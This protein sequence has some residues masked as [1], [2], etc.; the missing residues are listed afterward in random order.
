MSAFWFPVHSIL[1]DRGRLAAIHATRLVDQ[2]SSEA[3]DSLTR[4]ACR[5][6][7][8]PIALVTMVEVERQFFA[9]A[10]GLQEPEATRREIPISHS[11]CQQVVTSGEQLVVGDAC[12]DRR[13]CDNPAVVDFNIGAYLGVPLRTPDGFVLGSFCVLDT[14]EREWTADDIA[15]VEDL[16][17]AAMA[18]LQGRTVAGDL[19]KATLEYAALLD[20]TTELVCASDAVGA[21]T[22]VNKAWCRAFG[23]RDADVIG[24]R[25]VD[26]VV[27]EHRAR[28][29]EVARRVHEGECSEDFEVMAMGNVGRRVVCRGTARATMTAQEDGTLRCTGTIGVYRDVTH[30]RQQEAA[31]ARLVATLEATSDLVYIAAASGEIDYLNRGG[32][33]LLGMREDQDLSALRSTAFHPADTQRLLETVGMPTARERGEWQGDG[34]VR[35]LDGQCIPVSI[36][37]TAHPGITPRDSFYFSAIMWDRRKQVAAD[38]AIRASEARLRAVIDNAAV[39][40]SIVNE[41]GMV[42]Q[43]NRAFETFLGY[44]PGELEGR[45]APDLSPASDA[46]ITR[47]PVES[48]RSGALLS[49]SVEKRFTRTDGTERWAALTLSRIPL[50]EHEYGILGLTT[51]ITRRREAEAA[52]R[53]SQERYRRLVDL[54]PDG[55]VMYSGG[56][57]RFANAAMARLVGLESA[58]MVVG[59]SVLGFSHPAD[60]Q[61]IAERVQRVDTDGSVESIIEERLMCADGSVVHCEISS[62]PIMLHD[63]HGVLA[64]VRD[65]SERKRTEA[66]LRESE[67]AFRDLLETV[68]VIAV[69]LD[70]GGKVTFAN[71]ALVG[72]SGWTRE[73]VL[74]ADWF[75]RFLPDA[76]TM[77]RLFDAIMAGND[78]LAHYESD[79]VTRQGRRRHIVWDNT[80]LRDASG[81]IIGL[82]SI[83]QDVTDQRAAEA[84]LAELSE[85]DELT[86]LLNR[87][88]FVQRVDYG[89]LAAARARRHDVLLYVD[90]DRFKPINDTYGHAEGDAAL[91]AVARI[92]AGTIRQTDLAGRLGGDE[93]AIYAVGDGPE[94]NPDALVA[95]LHEALRLHN[96][97]QATKGRPYDIGFSV[98]YAESCPGDTRAALLAR[99]DTALYAIK[100]ARSEH[101]RP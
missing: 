75:G 26:L 101:A 82:A 79:L 62:S 31:R 48:L 69:T 18:D 11:L 20:S 61:R 54:S 39:G 43:A 45:F 41:A 78:V 1:S 64:V 33:R 13:V 7:A 49:A 17:R 32:R 52:L 97:E 22:Y 25:I 68:R 47:G 60:R 59:R 24:V 36:S 58:E 70:T 44:A 67:A 85:R 72:L 66:A 28:F 23:Y 5:L 90:L 83:G 100:N 10:C 63:Q 35:A 53:E 57:V 92:I 89:I 14:R 99:A 96:A 42:V 19:A 34:E 81:T 15:V 46:E 4:L 77:R 84:R 30:E 65:V 76:S 93:F 9:A 8:A 37:L 51:D 80:V 38:A 3:L 74:G 6:V 73:Q 29:L 56:V 55:I 98:G 12:S 86:G 2:P 40:V 50:S 91:Q 94:S 87:R 88:G 27:P 16:A 21:I 95:R 71:D